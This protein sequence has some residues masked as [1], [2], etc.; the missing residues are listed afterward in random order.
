MCSKLWSDRKIAFFVTTLDNQ[1][2]YMYNILIPYE[3]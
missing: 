3:V 2:P 1:Y